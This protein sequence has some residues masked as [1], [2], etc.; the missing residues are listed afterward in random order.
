MKL[1][2]KKYYQ[3]NFDKLVLLLLPTFLRKSKLVAFISVLIA[4]TKEMYNDFK[5]QQKK[6]W[7][8]LNHNGQVFSL[9]K[10]LNDHF[11]NEQRRID[12]IDFE[13]Y[14]RTYIYT[15]V[16][17]KPLY[18]NGEN[19]ETKYIYTS[20]EYINQFDFVVVVPADL[21]Y[22]LYKMRALIDEYKL[23]TK[24]YTIKNA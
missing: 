20:A 21:Q 14:Q 5:E 1:T 7:Y 3:I 6:D 23:I 22:N 10:V 8:R 19:E 13:T 17:G 9:R 2:N 4:P 12:I 11:D 24:K 16:E 15:P 18:I